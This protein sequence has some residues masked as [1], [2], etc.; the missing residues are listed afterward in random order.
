MLNKSLLLALVA[1]TCVFGPGEPVMCRTL[2][3]QLHIMRNTFPEE[4]NIQGGFCNLT[5]DGITEPAKVSF[6]DEN[7][8]LI[9]EAIERGE[10]EQVYKLAISE[11]M[12]SPEEIMVRLVHHRYHRDYNDY[13]IRLS[14]NGNRI[15]DFVLPDSA[16]SEHFNRLPAQD[17][18]LLPHEALIEGPELPL[19]EVLAQIT[20]VIKDVIADRLEGRHGEWI[21]E[22][23][24]GNSRFKFY[25][26]DDSHALYLRFEVISHT[27]N[28]EIRKL[29]SELGAT[30]TE[31]VRVGGLRS[32]RAT[33]DESVQSQ[34]L[35]GDTLIRLYAE[36]LTRDRLHTERYTLRNYT[37]EPLREPAPAEG[38]PAE[39]AAPAQELGAPAGAEQ[40][41]VQAE[42]A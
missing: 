12:L 30:V 39:A 32:F 1:M 14:H 6:I 13:R 20:H 18:Q 37:L 34:L 31:R 16:D 25:I 29:L 9:T 7:G 21:D 8:T 3:G 28:R 17:P 38:V 40:I 22:G 10:E 15:A 36:A 26:L 2:D 11:P 35:S 5:K 23:L 41:D 42:A 4:R 33:L 24:N 27:N 19:A